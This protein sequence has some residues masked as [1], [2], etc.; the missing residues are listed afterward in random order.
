MALKDTFRAFLR[1]I[2]FLTITVT[3]VITTAMGDILL[4][5]ISQSGVVRWKNKVIKWWARWSSK[6]LGFN[7]KVTGNPP[8]APFFLVSNHLSYVDVIP[9][10]YYL[11]ATFIAK[12]EIKSWPFFGWAT[13][14]LGVLFIDRQLRSDVKRMN[15]QIADSINAEQGVI[16]FPEGTSSK[17]KK[18]LP[19]KSSL[20]NYPAEKNMPVHYASISYRSLDTDRPAWSHVCWWGD[21]SFLPHFWELLKI[22]HIEVIIDFGES[23]SAKDR[24]VLS[25]K[26]QKAVSKSFKPVIT[27]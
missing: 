7:I 26:L 9:L 25:S 12:S 14:K 1:I 27:S 21:M 17:G 23:I 5:F 2:A 16:L 15:K 13:Q 22:K 11:D 4:G 6:V 19:F 18:V 8:E 10:W 3:T 20:L 24:K